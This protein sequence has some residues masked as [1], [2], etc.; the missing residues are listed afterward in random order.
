MARWIAFDEESTA[1]AAARTGKAISFQ[2]GDALESAL[3]SS[4]P[5]IVILPGASADDVLVV[6]VRRNTAAA[7][8][9]SAQP[10][11]HSQ[12]VAS[13]EPAGYEPAGFLGLADRPVFDREIAPKKKWWKRL[14]D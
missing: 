4:R 14:L 5:A 11:E 6:E 8:S 7:T 12:P 1:V 13:A 10:E 9:R 2:R 3:A